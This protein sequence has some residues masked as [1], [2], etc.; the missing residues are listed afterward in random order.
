M[1][2]QAMRRSISTMDASWRPKTVDPLGKAFGMPSQQ[3]RGFEL[4]LDLRTAEVTFA[5]QALVQLFYAVRRVVDEAGRALP[6]GAKVEGLLFDE[7]R[8][9]RA[10]AIG[11]DL[12]IFIQKMDG[13]LCNAT[14]KDSMEPLPAA[15]RA[16]ET[17]EGVYAAQKE[18]EE[19]RAADGG[20]MCVLALPAEP[21]LW[22]VALTGLE[23]DELE[24]REANE[25]A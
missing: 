6:K 25:G 3:E 21:M 19:L 22:A 16:A 24:C 9:D 18:L 10:D 17:L 12:P 23:P 14:V 4:W 15:L 1:Q 2:Q 13:K 8:Y 11:S 20:S 7:M 5:Q